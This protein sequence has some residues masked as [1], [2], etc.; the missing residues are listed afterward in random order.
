VQRRRQSAATMKEQDAAL[1][2]SQLL[3]GV[4]LF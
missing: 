1:E 4:T 3:I 2:R